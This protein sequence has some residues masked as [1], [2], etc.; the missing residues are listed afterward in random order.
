MRGTENWGKKPKAGVVAS[1]K[2]ARGRAVREQKVGARPTLG[3]LGVL[4][5]ICGHFPTA[6]KGYWGVLR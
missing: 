5:R 1:V 6:L 3:G 4:L 2:T